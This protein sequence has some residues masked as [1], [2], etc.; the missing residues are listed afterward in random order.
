MHTTSL[1]LQK[2]ILFLL[3]TLIFAMVL[4]EHLI[5][6]RCLFVDMPNAITGNQN[7]KHRAK[8][9]SKVPQSYRNHPEYQQKQPLD[10]AL[11][12]ESYELIHKRTAHSRIFQNQDGSFT[13][14]YSSTPLH[15]K[16]EQGWWKSFSDP[17]TPGKH[18]TSV[19][20]NTEQIESCFYPSFEQS[21]L[22][23]EVTEGHL[24]L[25]TYL[26][27]EFVATSSSGAWMADQRSYV[28][29][30]TGETQVFHGSGS[31]AGTQT[32]TTHSGV[33]AGVSPGEIT[34]SFFSS[35][36]W[37]G[38]GCNTEFNY[39]QR[40]YVEITHDDVEF[41]DGEVVINE[42]TASNRHMTD[43]FG[44]YEDWVEFY[45]PSASY[46]DLT[47][48]YL[49]DNPNNRTKWQ[50]P[51]GI[52]PPGGH[53][54]VYC[55]GR[56]AMVGQTP[57]AGFRLSQL[58]PEFILFSDPEGNLLE[59]YPLFVTQGG[60]SVGR[61]TSGAELW[62]VFENP[63]PGFFNTGHKNGYTEMPQFTIEGGFY[64][65]PVNVEISTQNTDL[66][67]RYT[68][69]GSEPTP[70]SPLYQGPITVSETQVIRARSFAAEEENLLPGFIKT[71]TFFI[72][73]SHTLP[74]FSFSGDE[75]FILFGGSQIETIG[76]YEFYDENGVFIDAAVGDFDKH[77]NDSWSYPQRGVD[78]VARD[79]YGYNDELRHKFFA[80]S[81]RSSFQRLMVKAA[82]NDNYPFEDGGAHIRDSYIQSLSQLIGLNM[83]ERSSTSV[84]VYVNGEYW[85]V[86]DLRE[87]VD[88][89]H[90]T[91]FYY[92]QPRKYKGSE[93][94]IQ[95]LKTWGGTEA[96][97]GEQRAIEDWAWLRY[98]INSH[99]MGDPEYF[100][101]V[102]S[103][104]DMESFIDHF[105]FNSYVVSRDWL[106]YNTGW[107]RGL[108][109][110]GEARKWRYILWDTEAALG[111]FHNY[112]G[113]PDITAYA[114]PCNVENITVGDGHAQSLKKLITENEQVWTHYV[115]RYND[116]LNTHLSYENAIHVLDSM[117]AVIEPEMPRQIERWGGNMA[118][119]EQNVQAIRDF[120]SIRTEALIDGLMDCYQLEGPYTAII[121]VVPENTGR[122]KLNSE[123][124]PH[125]PFT[126]SVFGA[127]QTTL[128]PQGF[129]GWTFSH[130]ETP[131]GMIF[132][133]PDDV[134]ALV[135]DM[136]SDREITA[137]FHN[138]NINNQD[139]IYYW[140]F[141]NLDPSD[142]NFTMVPADH[143][144]E[145]DMWANMIYEGIGAFNMDVYSTGSD[146]NL[147]L[148]EE[149][150]LAVRVR[151][152]SLNRSLLFEIPSTGYQDL[153]FEYAAHRSGQGMLE[154]HVYYTLDGE[155]FTQDHLIQ[156]SFSITETYELIALDF[157]HVAGANNNPDF[158]IRIEF[159]GNTAQSNGNN[160]F[161][162]ITLKGRT[163]IPS[164]IAEKEIPVVSVSPNPF[165]NFLWVTSS[166]HIMKVELFDVL[167]SRIWSQKA[168][169]GQ[170]KMSVSPAGLLPGVY[171][172]NVHTPLGET[173]TKVIKQ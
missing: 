159:E 137:H 72:N 53:L 55:S 173:K 110:D 164:T 121:N 91:D 154:H 88:D 64:E 84:I 13:T 92:N 99:N 14:A 141:N 28:S 81:D 171:F 144:I 142:D 17:Q 77:G 78:F 113:I 114:A 151:N 83:D 58:K 50:F 107:W 119:W 37:G 39:L 34:I 21:D 156:K 93:E 133:D 40:R 125:Y 63:S 136:Q 104:L 86:Y 152:P 7:E 60:H 29:G 85:G 62:G 115:N 36:V 109:P 166:H 33:A 71:H 123:W 128:Q 89:N 70:H 87:K 101:V 160:R 170:K 153:V 44:N 161:D 127:I 140:H 45:N 135:F 31:S 49:S 126:A 96:K 100:A 116:L 146:I 75:L 157:G 130:W 108:H 103:L 95:F 38:N 56:D 129:G 97:Y 46:V 48:Y 139:L 32:Y 106:N 24:I 35:R 102:D 155:Y 23:L 74:V 61:I 73:E 5:A 131:D 147:Q 117:I 68:T 124:L 4:P 51:G 6:Q 82:A 120:I 94:Y 80:T 149:A 54:L 162:N 19:I 57:H 169:S 30:P 134:T 148:I 1:P 98:F 65:S 52:V 26:L 15:Y 41:T 22:T 16:S 172:I 66:Q 112:T 158:Q 111:H 118:T 138:P 3:A 12:G 59:Q 8:A 150:G 47:G 105:V 20:D 9:I 11:K 2:L 132:T 76:A 67:I 10:P 122:V 79:E 145:E 25:N 90:F 18:P 167:G 165:G 27:W 43:D 143:L 163:Y 168:G 42:F 69:D